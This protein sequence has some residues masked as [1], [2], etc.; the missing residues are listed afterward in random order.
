MPLMPILILSIWERIHLVIRVLV[1]GI[2]LI[3][4]AITLQLVIKLETLTSDVLVSLYLSLKN[5]EVPRVL[6]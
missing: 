5:A 3:V 4:G 6:P 1:T 2:L